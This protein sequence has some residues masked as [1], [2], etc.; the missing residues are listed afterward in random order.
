MEEF[1]IE[2]V[3]HSNHLPKDWAPPVGCKGSP[4]PY[5]STYRYLEEYYLSKELI[6]HDI[7][8]IDIRNFVDNKISNGYQPVY[9]PRMI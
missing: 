1:W 5:Q 7:D 9:H 2:S 6:T 4:T 3:K 8:L